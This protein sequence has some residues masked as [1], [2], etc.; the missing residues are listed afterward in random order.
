MDRLRTNIVFDDHRFTV[1]VLQSLEFRTGSLDHKRFLMGSSKP[2]AVI[3]AE[4]DRSYALDMDA[5]LV[6]VDSIMPGSV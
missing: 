5:R 6:D 3:V 1:T 4:P 2:I